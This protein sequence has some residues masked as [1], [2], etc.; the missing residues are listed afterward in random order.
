MIDRK[1]GSNTFYFLAVLM[2][3]V[4]WWWI[5][6][7]DGEPVG[8]AVGVLFS[9]IGW[10]YSIG[11]IGTAIPR[12]SPFASL[13]GR[14]AWTLRPRPWILWWLAIILIVQIFGAPMILWNYG[15]GR[16]QYIDWHFEAHWRG[17]QG[18][19]AFAGCRVISSR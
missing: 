3:V 17:A 10:T 11:G 2:W 9:F 12:P 5:D 16:C 8:T 7:V 18:D 13:A 14:V 19:G 4:A 6:V 1:I 15:G